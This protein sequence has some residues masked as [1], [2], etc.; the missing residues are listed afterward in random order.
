M[1]AGCMDFVQKNFSYMTMSLAE[2][3]GRCATPD[4]FPPLIAPGERYDASVKHPDEVAL[5]SLACTLL[6]CECPLE[7]FQSVSRITLDA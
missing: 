3:T 7:L 2:L 4:A 1:R 6:G 5:Q